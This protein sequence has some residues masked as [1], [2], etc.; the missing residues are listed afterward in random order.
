MDTLWLVTP[1]HGRPALTRIVLEQRARLI[2]ELA[3]LG[4]QAE[5]VVVGN[6]GNLDTAR[7][8]GFHP[9]ECSNVL[10]LR[11][12]DG[13][14][15]ALRNGADHVAYV[16]SD[17]WLLPETWAELPTQGHARS[18][19]WI[20]FADGENIASVPASPSPGKVPWTLSRELLRPLGFRPA[21]DDAE[22]M[23]DSA[24]LDA[25]NTV[26][27]QDSVF[28]FHADD[29]PLRVVEF[30]NGPWDEQMTPWD[31]FVPAGF[32]RP[33]PFDVLATRYPADLCERMKEF[34]AK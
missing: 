25:I 27:H 19:A 24:L 10:G 23:L 28:E 2:D 20:T 8:F 11:I 15:Y 13:F 17:A 5:Q 34:Y 4:V 30:R 6:D 32:A 7:E 22:R 14:E 31:V 12:N 33:N 9:L 3:D 1:V 18:S 16:G 29:D 21:P 26:A